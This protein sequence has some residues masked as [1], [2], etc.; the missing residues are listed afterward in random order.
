M[1]F[2]VKGGMTAMLSRLLCSIVTPV[3]Y[4]STVKNPTNAASGSI[5]A[6]TQLSELNNHIS[7]SGQAVNP[8]NNPTI[9]TN[10]LSN[11]TPA[12]GVNP[13][14]SLYQKPSHQL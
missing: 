5:I 10:L 11:S 1:Q 14:N 9:K 13:K 4:A 7:L 8:V 12:T 2:L 6:N 3:S